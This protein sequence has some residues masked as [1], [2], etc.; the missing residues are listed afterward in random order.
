MKPPRFVLV[1]R[2][3]KG[4]LFRDL[5]GA[6]RGLWATAAHLI[7]KS[8]PQPHAPEPGTAVSPGAVHL[9]LADDGSPLCVACGLCTA[10]CPP[11]CLSVQRANIDPTTGPLLA[12]FDIDELRCIS[13]ARCV[14]IC[15]EDALDMSGPLAGASP[16]RQGGIK[17]LF[18]PQRG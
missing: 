3:H 14:E 17:R 10:V 5:L 13:C 8:V 1:P 18:G 7:E 2:P 15:P 12:A 11:R 16:S 9:R 6:G 4:G